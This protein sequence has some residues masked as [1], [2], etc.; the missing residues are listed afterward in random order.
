MSAARA[1][2]TSGQRHHVPPRLQSRIG[3]IPDIPSYDI[4]FSYH[5]FI[6]YLHPILFILFICLD[7]S[8]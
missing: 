3:P 7:L 2:L 5:I 1:G 4:L 8:V 6:Y